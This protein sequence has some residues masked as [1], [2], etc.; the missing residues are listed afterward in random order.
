MDIRDRSRGMYQSSRKPVF[1][2]ANDMIPEAPQPT[3]QPLQAAQPAAIT[4][5]PPPPQERSFEPP[6][7]FQPAKPTPEPS[8][9]GQH[10]KPSKRKML[11]D[12]LI[13]VALV[14][15]LGFFAISSIAANAKLHTTK[16]DLAYSQTQLI[17]AQK[18]LIEKKN[19]E[20]FVA[21]Y[22]DAN[23]SKVDC[24]S[25]P[26][27]MYDVHLNDK[28]A[29]YHY[30]CAEISDPVRIGAMKKLADGSYEFTYGSSTVKP[31]ALPSYIYDTDADFFSQTFGATRF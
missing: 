10:P 7:N 31:N 9:A 29:V 8:E 1:R 22:N 30:V 19:I 4:T 23:R 13:I 20:D 14:G 11:I 5:A 25:K 16:Q 17:N 21:K 18:V 28:F 24:S 27:V 12:L 3:V 6:A 15:L 2:S 26:E